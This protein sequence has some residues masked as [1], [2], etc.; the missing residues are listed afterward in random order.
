MRMKAIFRITC[1]GLLLTAFSSCVGVGGKDQLEYADTTYKEYCFGKNNELSMQLPTAILGDPYSLYSKNLRWKWVG[2]GFVDYYP[3]SDIRITKEKMDDEIKNILT[4]RLNSGPGDGFIISREMTVTIN[5]D[6]VLLAVMTGIYQKSPYGKE[7]LNRFVAEDN[8]LFEK[9]LRSVRIKSRNGKLLVIKVDYDAVKKK[10]QE[11]Y[12][13]PNRPS[14][15]IEIPYELVD[16]G[17][18]V[19][20]AQQTKVH[21]DKDAK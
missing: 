8:D 10:N 12:F 11:I 19:P 6:P 16:A 2:T 7:M 15:T 21:S 20:I 13:A 1:A 14:A 5:G 4:I 18:V 9:I 17:P 3:I